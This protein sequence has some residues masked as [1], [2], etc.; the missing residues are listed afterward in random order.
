[1]AG[2]VRDIAGA[3]LGHHET[4]SRRYTARMLEAGPPTRS[5]EPS[6]GELGSPDRASL[7]RA[8]RR[9]SWGALACLL[10]GMS[11]ARAIEAD[12]SRV[13]IE[14]L[15]SLSIVPVIIAPL[16]R[17]RFRG[18]C[19]ALA[20]IML[21]IGW[22]QARIIAPRDHPIAAQLNAAA[23]PLAFDG[24]DDSDRR[25]GADATRRDRRGSGVLLTVQG[26]ILDR[27]DASNPLRGTLAASRM[28]TPAARFRLS[29]ERVRTDRGWV[30]A[31]GVLR[32]R[33]S[34]VDGIDRAAL[35]TANGDAG[36]GDAVR[37]TGIA[38]GVPA[39][40]NPGERDPRHWAAQQ[41]VVG[42]LLVTDPRL[43][44]RLPSGDAVTDVSD[45]DLPSSGSDGSNGWRS[46]LAS[47]WIAFRVALNDRAARAITPDGA[48]T[49]ERD[50]QARALI[51]S[52]VL[53]LESQRE[54]RVAAAFTRLGVVHVL[55][56]S[57][58]HVAL[59]AGV[60]L[61]A[62]RLT[63][64][65]GW[66]EPA[67]TAVVVIAYMIV[68]PSS[69]P[70]FRAGVL[71]LV[72]LA[73]DALGRRYDRLCLLAWISLAL[74]LWH[75]ADAF[76]LGYALSV[77]LTAS[78]MA[79]GDRF[80]ARL[81]GIRLRGLVRRRRSWIDAPLDAGARFC[82]ATVL[83][84]CLS[85]P[86]IA[87]WTGVLS[88]LAVLASLVVVPLVSLLLALG[89]VTL[90]LGL[91]ESAIVGGESVVT[92]PLA[93]L[94]AIFADAILAIVHR[95]DRIDLA[96]IS[97]PPISLAWSA[98]ATLAIGFLLLRS[99]VRSPATWLVLALTSAALYLDAS[100]S[101]WTDQGLR[102]EEA[103]RTDALSLG[104]SMGVLLRVKT[105]DGHR[106]PARSILL[107]AGSMR[108]DSGSALIHSSIRA[109][110]AWRVPTIVVTGED[111]RHFAAIPDL[112]RPLGVRR[113]VMP[114]SLLDLAIEPH[115]PQAAMIAAIRS[116]GVRLEVV[117][118][119]R[120]L[121]LAENLWLQLTPT[122]SGSLIASVVCSSRSDPLMIATND[123]GAL[124]DEA[125]QPDA[126]D[127]I[128]AGV[129]ERAAFVGANS[130][131]RQRADVVILTGNAASPISIERFTREFAADVYVRCEA[132]PP[133]IARG[134]DP[135][136][137]HRTG[138]DGWFTMSWTRVRGSSAESIPR[139]R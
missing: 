134:E 105:S 6:E 62:I 71:V 112:L 135:P 50:L 84:W 39:P 118:E 99:R 9:R 115:T 24:T 113:V 89:F 103:V 58:F 106:L 46:R 19:F 10:T 78:L 42:S 11:L 22:W 72:L 7:I 49:A 133:L 25:D 2:S 3:S 70:V 15:L 109:L 1:V 66:I 26:R 98:F 137:L 73:A 45:V 36:A 30:D 85:A 34:G 54:D 93:S 64:D 127:A 57:G 27:P 139:E 63:G 32:V 67:L 81:F 117:V 31:S 74:A 41:G 38:S 77:G 138:R 102:S 4:A 28:Y 91:L 69:A 18:A 125:S 136:D 23:D 94:L 88:P 90:T 40:G 129:S 92:D 80:H 33:V 121:E 29:I 119:P 79:F 86:I 60:V 82:S 14:I 55:A 20:A 13:P 59:L 120:R 21:G 65:H 61:L 124:L 43:V 116:H 12:L 104:D 8:A 132:D 97:V 100:R 126:G 53:G 37:I 16:T 114:A 76:T 87:W 47:R 83:C 123:I 52:L 128:E 5:D 17:P 48:P 68:V 44:R 101:R 130:V 110:G 122:A 95:L 96:S 108:A 111:P 35:P 131:A 75:P 51:L 56:V 107:D